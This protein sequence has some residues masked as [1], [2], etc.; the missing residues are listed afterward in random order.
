MQWSLQDYLVAFNMLDGIGPKRLA[1]LVA[2]LGSLENAWHATYSELVQVPGIGP[3]L[4]QQIID[5]RR[6]VDPLEERKWAEQHASR[7]I[8]NLDKEDYPYWLRELANPPPVLYVKGQLPK[9]LGVAIIGSRRATQTGKSQAYNF[10]HRLASYGLPVISGLAMGIDTQAHLGAL[11]ANGFTVA[12]MAT[13]I[14]I[15]YPPQNYK[16]AKDIAASGCIITEFSSRSQTRP[17]SFPLRNRLIAAFSKAI[18][19]V[20][21]GQKSGTLS[22]VDAGLEIGRD[23]WAIPGDI[24]HPLRKGTHSLIKQGAGL[25][26][27]PED[28]LIAFPQVST[29]L[30]DDLDHDNQ[31]VFKY[32][33]QGYSPEKIV[34]LTGLP[35]QQVQ[36]LITLIEI[37]GLSNCSNDHRL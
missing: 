31:L 32:Y 26:D 11:A 21:A 10:A 34:E 27:S 37:D 17:G 16:L 12:V 24:A 6:L 20:E 19:V 9:Q 8:T 18:L 25:A 30:A 23:V 1:A 4:A 14:S 13:P 22:T 29:N 5:Q 28:L 2:F 36:N 35:V 3:R 15:V 7:I 33:L